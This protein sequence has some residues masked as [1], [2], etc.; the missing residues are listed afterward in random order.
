MYTDLSR[1][2]EGG[3][4]DEVPDR[5]AGSCLTTLIP[6][7]ADPLQ[8]L[9][10]LQTAAADVFQPPLR[11]EDSLSEQSRRQ[12]RTFRELFEDHLSH[13]SALL[14]AVNSYV[15]GSQARPP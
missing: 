1:A 2:G 3:P 4:V 12:F 10:R 11:F 6:S 7:D 5:T 9:T 15:A 14:R 8:S 13:V